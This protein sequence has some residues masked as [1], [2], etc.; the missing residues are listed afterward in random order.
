MWLEHTQL[1]VSLEVRP[2][3]CVRSV[4]SGGLSW[5]HFVVHIMVWFSYEMVGVENLAIL[6]QGKGTE[7]SVLCSFPGDHKGDFGMQVP[8]FQAQN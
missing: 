1:L 7:L 4:L 8:L 3:A 5:V 2:A 6:S